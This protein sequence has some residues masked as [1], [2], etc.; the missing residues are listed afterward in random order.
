MLRYD[1]K[2]V[3]PGS[4]KAFGLRRELVIPANLAGK[5]VLLN[6]ETTGGL[7]G[8]LVNGTWVRRFHHHI[9]TRF[10]LNITPWVKFGQKNEIELVGMGGISAGNVQSVNLGFHD[11]KAYP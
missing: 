6:V 7:T 9:G 1:Q 8:A 4:Y 3:L 5:N 2:S 10:D 11:P